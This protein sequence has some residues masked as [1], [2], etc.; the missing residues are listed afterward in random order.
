MRHS[1]KELSTA[2]NRWRKAAVTLCS[3]LTVFIQ[4]FWNGPTSEPVTTKVL[5]LSAMVALSDS[6]L[7]HVRS[8]TKLE[9]LKQFMLFLPEPAAWMAECSN[10]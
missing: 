3:P 1:L 9:L 7:I 8:R 6:L 4:I 5:A 2:F 10:S